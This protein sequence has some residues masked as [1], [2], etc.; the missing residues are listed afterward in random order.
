MNLKSIISAFFLMLL[1]SIS[2]NG[3]AQEVKLPIAGNAVLIQNAKEHPESL[4][5]QKNV[6][7]ALTL[8]F[9]DDF[10]TSYIYPDSTKWIG[11]SVYINDDFPIDPPTIGVATFDG[12]DSVG[13]PYLNATYDYPADTLTSQLINLSAA[14]ASDST[15]YL[16]FY[17]QAAGN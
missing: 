1:V 14:L 12:L 9:F 17:Y 6:Q 3:N 16:S 5:H 13:K 2:L 4:H 7:S 11:R 10:S 8:P 15:I